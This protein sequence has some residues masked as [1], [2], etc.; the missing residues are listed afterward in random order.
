MGV[1]ERDRFP[2]LHGPYKAPPCEVGDKLT[3]AL[4]GELIVVGFTDAP[5]P[6]PLGQIAEWQEPR[7]YVL[8]G[9]LLRAVRDES[10][11]T[12]AQ[13]WGVSQT[14][15]WAW[16][17]ALFDP[18]RRQRL[19]GHWARQQQMAERMRRRRAAL[20]ARVPRW[21]PEWDALLGTEPD[22]AL[23]KR[24]GVSLNTVQAHR[25]QLGVPGFGTNG[26][27][28]ARVWTKA[29]ERLLGTM[30]D[31]ELA[32]RLGC[33]LAMVYSRRARL[34]IPAFARRHVRGKRR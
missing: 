22:R 14:Q 4:R 23:A 13:A 20:A 21:R 12:I 6:W 28:R 27:Q 17:H 7:Y 29:E 10:L 11:R 32:C 33:T 5:V 2:L 30:P 1:N 3:C 34:G 8:C 24:L 31:R 26:V 15:A 25:K 16:R 18:E 9:D 19:A